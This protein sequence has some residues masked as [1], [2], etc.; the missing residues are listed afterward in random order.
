[1]KLI[2]DS[3]GEH[4]Q[5]NEPGTALRIANRNEIPLLLED[6]LTEEISELKQSRFRD[7][8]EFADVFEVL[9]ALALVNGF[10]EADITKARKTKNATT[11]SFKKGFV[12][13]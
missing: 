10:S 1:M 8:N 3:I 12:L 9:A 2:R 5:K 4:I 6:K 11:G 7:I 13:G